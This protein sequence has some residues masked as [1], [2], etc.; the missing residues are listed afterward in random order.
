MVHSELNAA[1]SAYAKGAKII[2]RNLTVKSMYNTNGEGSTS[3]VGAPLV[4]ASLVS[5]RANVGIARSNS[6]VSAYV[7]DLS[8]ELSGNLTVDTNA[9]SYARSLVGAPTV[10]V[11]AFIIKSVA[12]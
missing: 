6:T 4:S 3:T 5:A 1:Q 9:R 2:A 12:S 11:G 7:G 10:S 8:T